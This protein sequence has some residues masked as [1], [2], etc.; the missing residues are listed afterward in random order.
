MWSV[1]LILVVLVLLTGCQQEYKGDVGGASAGDKQIVSEVGQ[2]QYNDQCADCHGATGEGGSGG[3]VINCAQCSSIDV[4]AEYIEESMPTA[5]KEGECVGLCAV[6]TAEYILDA[7]HDTSVS[8]GEA[9]II[10]TKRLNANATL[11]KATIKLAGRLPSTE[12]KSLTD[13]LDEDGLSPALDLVLETDYAYNRRIDFYTNLFMPNRYFSINTRGKKMIVGDRKYRRA[14]VHTLF[15]DLTDLPNVENLDEVNGA[16]AKLL[17]RIV[18]N[19]ASNNWSI[20][21]VVKSIVMSDDFRT[22]NLAVNGLAIDENT[23]TERHLSPEELQQKIRRILGDE[24]NGFINKDQLTHAEAN[25]SNDQAGQ[26]QD[27]TGFMFTMQQNI[28][29]DMACRSVLKDFRPD[30]LSK[31]S[32]RLLFPYVTSVLAPEDSNGFSVPS[33]VNA[34]KRNIQYLHWH[35]LNEFVATNSVEKNSTYKIFY[36]VWN[37]GNTIL[38]NQ[39]EGDLISN[40]DLS[41]ELLSICGDEQIITENSAWLKSGGERDKDNEHVIRAWIAVVAYLLSDKKFIVE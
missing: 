26:Q 19:M 33:N 18:D 29:V 34:I 41:Y 38:L 1:R 10:T 4:L 40:Q 21:T 22:K 7:F 27:N 32:N 39:T 17:D 2:Q 36:D 37:G 15:Q 25:G 14:V 9:K 24:W 35:L 23:R 20:K 12:E 6:D 13:N 3:P 5:G 28:A 11:Q 16:Q 8:D 31:K 30:P